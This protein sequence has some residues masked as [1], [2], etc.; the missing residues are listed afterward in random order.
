MTETTHQAPATPVPIVKPDELPANPQSVKRRRKNDEIVFQVHPVNEF[1]RIAIDDPA[2]SN[3]VRYAAQELFL[4]DN[5]LVHGRF[6]TCCWENS[7][8]YVDEQASE[9]I[10]QAIQVMLKN[11][12][13]H[14]I[15]RRKHFKV[16][17]DRKFYYDL[18]CC[19]I[20]DP[21]V[22]NSMTRVKNDQE[23][24]VIER[25]ASEEASF[26]SSFEDFSVRRKKI[27]LIDVYR[28]L[29]DKNV[30]PCHSVAMLA[31]ERITMAIN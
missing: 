30:F 13:T 17:G 5:S 21:S 10:V 20:K 29:K 27:S 26:V 25:K 19:D 22:R 18:G 6:L 2:K 24:P 3:A 15:M 9:V 8:E 11:I 7:L 28:T 1:V 12:I 14:C 31:M 23:V 4:P 16:T